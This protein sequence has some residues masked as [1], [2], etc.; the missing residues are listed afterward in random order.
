M[1][2][3]L[4]EVEEIDL[5]KFDFSGITSTNNMF[6]NC[7]ILKR[8]EF[9][10]VNIPSLTNMEYMFTGCKNL[11]SIDISKFNTSKVK[12][13][14]F[15]FDECINIKKIE[16]GN[17]DT[18]SVTSFGGL[19]RYC[20]KIELIGISNF[21]ASSLTDMFHLFFHCYAL[22][23]IVFPE[24]LDT[25]QVIDVNAMFSHCNSL[26]ALNLSNFQLTNDAYIGYMFNSCINLKYIDFSNFPPITIYQISRMFRNLTSLVYLN[27]PSLE[28]FSNSD[29]TNTFLLYSNNPYKVCAKQENMKKYLS[30]QNIINNCD[31]ICFKNNIKIGFNNNI[32]IESCKENGYDFEY[33]NICYNECPEYTHSIHI[34]NKNDTLIC[35]DKKPQG[36]YLDTDGFYKK[37]YDPC[38]LCDE[39]GNEIEHNCT[40]CKKDYFFFN[41]SFYQNNCYQKCPNYY[42]YDDNY[43]YHCT[44]NCSVIYYKLIVNSIKCINNCEKDSMYKY[45]Y[46]QI[47]YEECYDG[48]NSEKEG[49]CLD[50]NIYQYINTTNNKI[51]GDNEEIFRRIKDK[52]LFNY[53]ISNREEMIINGKDNFYFQITNSKNDKELLNEENNKTNKF[54][55]LDLGTCE[56]ILKN[57]YHINMN[58]SLLIIKNEK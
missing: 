34:E 7:E 27:I 9:G 15:V 56:I 20:E 29:M 6:A 46:D 37:C 11:E 40:M 33:L 25:T 39:K 23:V 14:Y 1:F 2:Y 55:V 32:C 51:I 49:I 18:S 16:L 10:N 4:K 53:N 45:E 26:I 47:C 54:T 38:K 22:K 44:D 36:Y 30:E 21:N 3:E 17:I 48:I 31:D 24:N 58:D 19:F 13:L 8:I 28:K 12:S 5:S 42:Y 41:D 35:L 43:I 50:A 52:S 57:Y